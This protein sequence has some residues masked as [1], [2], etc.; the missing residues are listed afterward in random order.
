M[1]YS[2]TKF[3]PKCSSYKPL[4][5]YKQCEESDMGT[6]LCFFQVYH[7]GPFWHLFECTNIE[8]NGLIMIVLYKKI[9]RV[10]G[11]IPEIYTR[12]Y[13]V[14]TIPFYIWQNSWIINEIVSI[15]NI[16]PH[17]YPPVIV[18]D[19]PTKYEAIRKTFQLRVFLEPYFRPPLTPY[20]ENRNHTLLRTLHIHQVP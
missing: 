1:C 9:K 2:D 18:L 15:G 11:I 14:W 6:W 20:L 17:S 3:V 4:Y 8:K 16:S 7:S 12:S 5:V 13:D 10:P 19:L